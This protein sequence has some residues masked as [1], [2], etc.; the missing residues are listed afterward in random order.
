M[1]AGAREGYSW[2]TVNTRDLAEMAS[3]RWEMKNSFMNSFH[4]KTWRMN[5]S[6]FKLFEIFGNT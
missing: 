6:V 5:L 3:F 2:S 4:M 1:L